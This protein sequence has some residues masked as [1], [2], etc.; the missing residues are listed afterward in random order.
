SIGVGTV[1]VDAIHLNLTALAFTGAI[2]IATGLLFG[3]A[4]AIQA[5]RPELTQS[6]KTDTGTSARSAV[7]RRVSMRDALIAFE[8]ALAVILLAGSGVLVRSLLELTAV[9]P[10]F[11]P[12]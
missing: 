3:L 12:Q 9:R 1:F 10:G 2:A 6:L 8:I 7:S 11:E 5:T 4:P